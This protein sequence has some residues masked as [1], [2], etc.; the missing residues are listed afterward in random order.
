MNCPQPIPVRLSSER[1]QLM[2]A[3]KGCTY[4]TPVV[5]DRRTAQQAFD[6]EHG[7]KP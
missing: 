3:A 2:C 4:R 5:A 6:S 1:V 7:G